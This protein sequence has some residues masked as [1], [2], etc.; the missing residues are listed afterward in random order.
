MGLFRTPEENKLLSALAE[1]GASGPWVSALDAWRAFKDYG[2][3]VKL[4]GG[5]G[6][7]FQVGTY[8]FEGRP[9]FYFNPVCQSE[10]VGADG[11]HEGFDQ[12]HCELSSQPGPATEGV[13]TTLWSFEF[14]DAEA[15]Y[16]AVEALPEF[17]IA[18]SQGKYRL[19]VGHE[20][21]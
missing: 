2:R 18:V 16:A 20:R 12:L 21:V 9:L 5:T 8:D 15:F 19:A 6:L 13:E 4:E 11:E 17:Q 3:S 1:H 10:F 14:P 7:L